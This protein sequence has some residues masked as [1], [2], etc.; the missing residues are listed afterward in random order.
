MIS[1]P[2][3]PHAPAASLN[4]GRVPFNEMTDPSYC[5]DSAELLRAAEVTS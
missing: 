5:G 1:K 2:A 3:P 4:G